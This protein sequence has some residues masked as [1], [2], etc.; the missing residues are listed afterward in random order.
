[1]RKGNMPKVLTVKKCFDLL[2]CLAS[3][4]AGIGTRELARVLGMNVTTVHN[5]AST[6]LHLGYLSQDEKSKRFQI[7]GRF[8][9]L[10]QHRQ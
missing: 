3:Q 4:E 7:G 5:I 10:G 8:L 9:L 1:M 6:L 2:E